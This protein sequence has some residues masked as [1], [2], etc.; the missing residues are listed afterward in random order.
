M[1]SRNLSDIE[2][3]QAVTANKLAKKITLLGALHLLAM[4]WNQVSKNTI[5]N[6]LNEAGS[7]KV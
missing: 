1:N 4:S 2:E 5:K 3:N 6:C 7:L